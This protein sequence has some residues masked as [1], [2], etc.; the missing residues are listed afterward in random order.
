MSS[1]RTEKLAHAILETVSTTILFHLKDPRVKNVTVLNVEVA[2]DM[3]TAKV[4]VSVMGDEKTQSL[5]MHGLRS[6][7]GFIQSKLASRLD[8]RYIPVLTFV[9]DQSVKLAA[10]ASRILREVLP[11]DEMQT[12]DELSAGDLSEGGHPQD[13]DDAPRE[14]ADDSAEPGDEED[15]SR[16][17]FSPASQRSPP[18]T[19]TDTVE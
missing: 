14:Q 16:A 13:D 12:H 9:L 4:Y 8:T 11:P 6:A 7:R 2:G 3:R 5:C 10:E 18:E 15:D 19:P 1:R 17:S